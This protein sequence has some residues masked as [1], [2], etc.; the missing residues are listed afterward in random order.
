MPLRKY[1][2]VYY[3]EDETDNLIQL[4]NFILC[5]ADWKTKQIYFQG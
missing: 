5:I 4:V 1:V 3:I 2:L